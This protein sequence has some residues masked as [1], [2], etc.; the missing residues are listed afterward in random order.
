MYVALVS[1]HQNLFCG[2][3]QP[4]KT[5]DHRSDLR[6]KELKEKPGKDGGLRRGDR[7]ADIAWSNFLEC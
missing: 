1:R 5:S 6:E 2:S 7:A 4:T 3:V